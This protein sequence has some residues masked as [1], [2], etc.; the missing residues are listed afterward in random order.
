MQLGYLDAKTEKIIRAS[1]AVRATMAG[2]EQQI[3]D[4]D[5]ER[6]RIGA[7][8][9][10]IRANLVPLGER[11]SEKELRERYIRTLNQQEDRIVAIADKRTEASESLTSARKELEDSLN[12]LKSDGAVKA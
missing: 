1:F 3:R 7:E 8:Q 10:R 2:Y 5:A 12:G 11:S 4:L 6:T 9:E